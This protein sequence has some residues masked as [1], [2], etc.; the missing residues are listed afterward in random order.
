M[1]STYTVKPGDT[2]SRIAKQYKTTVTELQRLNKIE[3]PNKIRAG[4]VIAVPDTFETPRTY[5]VAK[6]D[7]LYRIAKQFNTTVAELQRL[8]KIE[9]AG[10]IKVGQVLTLPSVSVPAFTAE[11]FL[12]NL[13]KGGFDFLKNNLEVTF[14]DY[15]VTRDPVEPFTWNMAAKMMG[16]ATMTVT[17]KGNLLTIV[18]DNSGI[19]ATVTVDN[20]KEPYFDMM[21]E[22]MAKAI[23]DCKVK[24]N[25]AHQDASAAT[26]R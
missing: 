23:V 22:S 19:G 4:Q 26:P 9:D 14:S 15:N 24:L 13:Q 6:G 21:Y 12:T 7:T 25:H 5:T 16:D 17:V 18:S 1:S 10:K 3:D 8:N 2:L 11:S 20:T